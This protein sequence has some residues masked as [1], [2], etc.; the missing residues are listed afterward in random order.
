ME[1]EWITG[2]FSVAKWTGDYPITDLGQ[3]SF[4]GKTEVETSLMCKS[5]LVPEGTQAREDGWKG[6]RVV[7]QLEFSLVGILAKISASLAEAGVSIYAVSTFDTDYVFLKEEMAPLAVEALEK[8]G[9][10]FRK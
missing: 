4:W 10:F 9:W 2:A 8:N 1:L 6:F 5:Q 3:F 7:G